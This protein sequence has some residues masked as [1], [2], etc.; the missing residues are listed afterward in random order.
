[1][2]QKSADS[3]ETIQEFIKTSLFNKIDDEEYW[4]ERCGT[5]DVDEIQKLL[6]WVKENGTKSWIEFSKKLPTKTPR[7]IR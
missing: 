4:E 3:E 6:K 7:Q 1:L 2:V 5:W